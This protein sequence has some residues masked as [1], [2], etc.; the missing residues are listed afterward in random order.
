[1]LIGCV[2]DAHLG[3]TGDG[4]QLARL[5]HAARVTVQLAGVR[6]GCPGMADVCGVVGPDQCPAV[7][8]KLGR[9]WWLGEETHD[10]Q[11]SMLCGRARECRPQWVAQNAA[12]IALRRQGAQCAMA[13]ARGRTLG[14]VGDVT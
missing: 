2:A 8:G 5:R 3:A 1:M 10:D 14:R 13:S 4:C 6:G 9:R 12:Y 11:C 7:D